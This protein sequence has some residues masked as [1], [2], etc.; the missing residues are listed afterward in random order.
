MKSK[1]LLFN[2]KK[3]LQLLATVSE[4]ILLDLETK[5]KN[6]KEKLSIDLMNLCFFY[7]NDTSI[8]HCDILLADV[9]C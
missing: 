6:N 1:L 4:E 2:C 5:T 7:F 8:F 9:A 3:K